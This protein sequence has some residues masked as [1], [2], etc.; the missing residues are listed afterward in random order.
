MYVFVCVCVC[1]CLCVVKYFN[2]AE[3]KLRL[4]LNDLCA[5]SLRN[6]LEFVFSPDVILSG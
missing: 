5:E 1:V 4:F 2:C 6:G 3:G